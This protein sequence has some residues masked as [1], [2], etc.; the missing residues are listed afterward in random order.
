MRYN[1]RNWDNTGND[2][3]KNDFKRIEDGIEANDA[4]ISNMK[5][6]SLE[7]SLAEQIANN[8]AQINVLN[9]NMR[10][11]GIE[12]VPAQNGGDANDIKE[13]GIRFVFNVEHIPSGYSYG[14][15]ETF[16]LEASGFSP[17]N[18]GVVIQRFTDWYSGYVFT[19]AY[20]QE[21]WS[22]WNCPDA[23]IEALQQ[24]LSATQEMLVSMT[25]L[26]V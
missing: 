23:K 22:E 5:D 13:T 4:E 2:V 21:S 12:T 24:Q 6:E 8:N 15:L 1:K 11:F 25:N 19:R 17:S 18:K 20:R 26:E 9:G 3:T 7:G 16:N 10:R 14:M